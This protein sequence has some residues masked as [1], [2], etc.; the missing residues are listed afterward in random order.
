M[1]FTHSSRIFALVDANNFY[2]SC[3]RVFRPALVGKPIVV[4]SNNDGC[5]IARSNETKALGIRMGEP[6]Y[7]AKPLIQAHGVHVFSANFALYGDL[8]ARVMSSLSEFAPE[9]EIYSIDEAFL[10]L[11]GMQRH[12]LNAYGRQMKQLV[13]Q[14]TG[15]PISVGIAETKTLA[16]MANYLAKK[17]KKANGV[18]DL[19][20]SPH[21]TRA[22]QQVPVGEVW[23]VGR[24]FAEKL[25]RHGIQTAFDLAQGNDAWLFQHFP[26]PLLR[27][28]QELRGVAC[29]SLEQAP[30]PKSIACSRSFA[31]PEEDLGKLR[32]SVAA[33]TAHAAERLRKAKMACQR[34]LVFIHTNRFRQNVSQHFDSTSIGLPTA[35][36][37]TAELI[38]VA[39]R[40]LA[41]IYKEGY[42]YH[43]AGVVLLDL[44]P[45][46]E[47]QQ[48]LWDTVNRSQRST[49]MQALDQI[50]RDFGSGAIRYAAE[51]LCPRWRMKQEHRSPRYTT[52]WSE[53]AQVNA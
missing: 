23:G 49:L 22:L 26:A 40:A 20:R 8:S 17:S 42:A 2:A 1:S 18:L 37:D 52:C 5:I 14:W 30:I 25:Q 15:I 19:T 13:E 27:T 34:L 33:Y 43:K 41:Q 48:N 9:M 28:V 11:S 51:G 4:L 29:L 16:Q 31:Q 10:D 32:E 12:H 24:K 6:F 53:L 39:H 38:Q 44:V 36:E 35:S 45:A 21:R 50:N 46:N 7:K 47:V 3:E